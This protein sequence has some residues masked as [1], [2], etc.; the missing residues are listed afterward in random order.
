MQ[1]LVVDDEIAIIELLTDILSDEGYDVAWAYDGK[2][3]LSLIRSGK[4]PEIVITD[5]MMPNLDGIGLYHAIRSEF[6]VEQIG[7]LLMSAGG[8]KVELSDP[9][10]IFIPKPFSIDD[11]L[12]AIERLAK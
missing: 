11:L 3:A 5:L 7:V 4:Y 2:H 8:R 9:R 10:A 6:G 1:V 12:A